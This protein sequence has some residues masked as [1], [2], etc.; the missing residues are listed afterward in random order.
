MKY[1]EIIMKNIIDIMVLL[2]ILN[3]T[4][5]DVTDFWFNGL[6]LLTDNQPRFGLKSN[7]VKESPVGGGRVC[8]IIHWNLG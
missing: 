3:L 8:N 5:P 2:S 1:T 4:D 6:C 7:S